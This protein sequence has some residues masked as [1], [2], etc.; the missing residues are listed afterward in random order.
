M[1][2]LLAPLA[3]RRA[4]RALVAGRT[5]TALRLY[6]RLARRARA[7]RGD[8]LRCADLL[9]SNGEANEAIRLLESWA[10]ADP[11]LRHRLAEAQMRAGRHEEG[12]RTIAALVREG[13]LPPAA[14]LHLGATLAEQGDTLR[15]E[16]FF[17]DSFHGAEE[18]EIRRAAWRHYA[19]MAEAAGRH[20]TALERWKLL[21]AFA[22]L[23]AEDWRHI[24]TLAARRG[25]RETVREAIAQLP[26][27]EDV[28]ALRQLLAEREQ[29]WDAA[30]CAAEDRLRLASSDDDRAELY[31]TLMRYAV[32]AG[33]DRGAARA[34]FAFRRH[35]PG[36]AGRESNAVVQAA[37][38]LRR[39]GRPASAEA[40]LRAHVAQQETDDARPALLLAEVLLGQGRRAEARTLLDSAQPKDR[41][42][43]ARL[44]RLR[45]YLAWAEGAR[46]EA[47][48]LFRD[49]NV[50]GHATE[51]STLREVEAWA[52]LGDTR[53]RSLALRRALADF[54]DSLPLTRHA[55]LFAEEEGDW[56]SAVK[57]WGHC[58]EHHPDDREVTHR[59]AL[60][61]LEARRPYHFVSVADDLAPDEERGDEGARAPEEPAP[62]AT[63]H[64]RLVA[65]YRRLLRD[66][67]WDATDE[68]AAL[69]QL[70][71]DEADRAAL[72]RFRER[73]ARASVS[74]RQKGDPAAPRS[75]DAREPTARGA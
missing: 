41:A 56:E 68:S 2:V 73:A 50:T 48:G 7:A 44:T 20:E 47:A 40:V 74:A 31:R 38:A 34:F 30:R 6:R 65:A 52:T 5:A 45:G 25:E 54:P 57:A 72:E 69:A 3:R 19:A 22:P 10:G 36:L 43:M 1:I 75:K 9:E 55:A 17:S 21:S 15:A 46:L 27:P 62:S 53:E 14:L 32:R 23:E 60:A 49:S 70:A 26:D 33:D 67:G 71:N 42:E 16:G 39:L 37:Q 59:L 8:R 11:A 28:A 66:P 35:V 12:A 13:A 58:A 61:L 4:E 29:D 63:F 64:G 18:P 51:P 24:G